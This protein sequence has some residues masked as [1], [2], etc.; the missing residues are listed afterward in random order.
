MKKSIANKWVKALK[1]GEYLQ[2]TNELTK[3]NDSGQD[4]FCC[5]GVLTNLYVQ[6]NGVSELESDYWER[7]EDGDGLLSKPVKEWAGMG[8]TNGRIPNKIYGKGHLAILN[9]NGKDFN[10]I[11]DVITKYKDKL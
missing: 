11:A 6:E 10:T 3:Q 4:T 9:D 2:C 7:N 5:L 1:S 8:S